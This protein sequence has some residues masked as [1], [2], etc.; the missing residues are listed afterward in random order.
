MATYQLPEI[1]TPARV[2]P[3]QVLLVANGDLRL[4]ANQN[5]WPA[6]QEMEESLTHAITDAGY[7]LLRAHPYKEDERHGFI[8][9]QKEGMDVFRQID[10]TAKL[11]VAEAVW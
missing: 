8:G 9:S 6:Q 5:C 7:E 10:P 4:S 2:Q 1:S 11:I 3:H